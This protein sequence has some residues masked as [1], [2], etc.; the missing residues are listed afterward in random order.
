TV[1]N[2]MK[3]RNWVGLFTAAAVLPWQS[4][5]AQPA[6][7]DTVAETP[8][9]VQSSAT[10][11]TDLSPAAAEVVRLAESGVGDEVVVSYIQNYKAA[12]ALPADHILYLKDL[13]V[14]SETITAMLNHDKS[15]P[16]API[17][18]PA[19]APAPSTP[20]APQWT[21]QPTQ[22]APAVAP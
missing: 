7:N 2:F 5:Y 10:A 13:G 21:T 9:Q 1:F 18:A 11:P 6:P 4:I 20:S 17:A 3:I 16:P 15:L 22:P 8:P 14:A 19:P 12:F